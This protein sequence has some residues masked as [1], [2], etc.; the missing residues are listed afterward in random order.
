MRPVAEYGIILMMETSNSQLSKLDRL[1]HFAEK[2]CSS[3]FTPLHR[4]HNAEI[5]EWELSNQRFCPTYLSSISLPQ[6]SQHLNTPQ[7]FLLSDSVTV[8]LPPWTW[9]FIGCAA[10]IWNHTQL[11]HIRPTV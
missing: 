9:N 4:H 2:L 5:I 1:G 3:Q 6:R 7:P 11:D 8:K 10:E